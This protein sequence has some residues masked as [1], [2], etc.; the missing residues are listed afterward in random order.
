LEV[1]KKELTTQEFESEY[2]IYKKMSK[3]NKQWERQKSVKILS[4]GVQYFISKVF[5]DSKQMTAVTKNKKTKK[6]KRGNKS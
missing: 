5:Q 2:K 3:E 1:F 6:K 4:G